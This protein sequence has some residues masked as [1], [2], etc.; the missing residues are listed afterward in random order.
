MGCGGWSG[1]RSAVSVSVAIPVGLILG[2]V[3]LGCWGGWERGFF[4]VT[5]ALF[6]FF[7][8]A[9]E[10]GGCGFDGWWGGVLGEADWR[11]GGVGSGRWVVGEG[12]D[13]DFGD[14]LDGAGEDEGGEEDTEED[15]GGE[16][17]GDDQDGAG[18]FA[19]GRGGFAF[20][21]LEALGDGVEAAVHGFLVLGGESFF[22]GIDSV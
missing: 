9:D 6:E 16:A 4:E 18:I 13:D 7:E 22:Q 10:A 12:F 3:W 8:G 5:D 19:G 11:G 2:R 20:L 1:E 15:G 14:A 21:R 17:T